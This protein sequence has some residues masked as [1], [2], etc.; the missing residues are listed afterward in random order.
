MWYNDFDDVS[1]REAWQAKQRWRRL[2]GSF[3]KFSTKTSMDVPSMKGS[4]MDIPAVNYGIFSMK[5]S[6]R[7][8][9][10][11]SRYRYHT[12]RRARGHRGL[13]FQCFPCSSVLASLASLFRSCREWLQA[14][15]KGTP[16]KHQGEFFPFFTRLLNGGCTMPRVVMMTIPIFIYSVS[17]CH[18]HSRRQINDDSCCWAKSLSKNQNTRVLEEEV[19]NKNS[20]AGTKNTIITCPQSF[21]RQEASVRR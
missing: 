7:W 19:C 8:G 4:D 21:T 20:V 2:R 15:E 10:N 18:P 5:D 14:E 3:W 17:S 6:I 9:E 16:S 12:V 11:S 13:R 1:S